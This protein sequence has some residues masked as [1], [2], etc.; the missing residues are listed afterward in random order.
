MIATALAFSGH[1]GSGKSTLSRAVADA[2]GAARVSFGDHVRAVARHQGEPETRER[3]QAI[4]EALVASKMNDFCQSV[5]DQA[6]A[7]PS[8]HVVID[9]VRHAEVV[10]CLRNLVTPRRLL[11]VYVETDISTRR[12]RRADRSA[13][14]QVGNDDAHSTEVQVASVLRRLADL[15]VS[16]SDDPPTVVQHVLDWLSRV[17][18]PSSA[19]TNGGGAIPRFSGGRIAKHAS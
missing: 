16:G 13:D 10:E 4:G 9:G 15:T 19:N 5:L 17:D 2:I 3:L 6:N 12:S 7:A 11:L 18:L 8:E 14:D 1:I